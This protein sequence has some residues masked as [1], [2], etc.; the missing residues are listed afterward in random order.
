LD[1]KRLILPAGWEQVKIGRAVFRYVEHELF[2]YAETKLLLRELQQSVIESTPYC[3][4]IPSSGHI[5]D[6]TANK[7]IRLVT[8]TAIAR[9]E[10]NVRAI[11][12]ALKLLPEQH[13]MLFNLRYQQ[14]K[15]IIMVCDEIPASERSYFRWRKEIVEITARE[16]GLVNVA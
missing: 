16:M 8:S 10:R 4:T 2:N 14:G 9:M 5:S 7:A 13:Q 11:D 15:S 1:G 3:E 12:R 6:P